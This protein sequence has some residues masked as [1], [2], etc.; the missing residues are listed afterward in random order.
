MGDD[1]DRVFKVEQEILQ[2]L[3]GSEIQVVGRLVE[4]QDIRIAKERLSKQHL[5]LIIAVEL[6]HF[7][8]MLL[9]FN[10]KGV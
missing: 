10:A 9:V 2:P 3:Y 1:N 6:L 4:Q 8:G 5:H 7:G